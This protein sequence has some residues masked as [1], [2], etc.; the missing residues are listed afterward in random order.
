MSNYTVIGFLI[1]AVYRS[2]PGISSRVSLAGNPAASMWE[3]NP[4]TSM[5][6]Q[7]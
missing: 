7:Y 6:T 5:K 1:L 2:G 3:W 4:A